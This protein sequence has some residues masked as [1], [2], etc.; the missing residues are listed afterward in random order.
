MKI[1]A[2]NA[3]GYLITSQGRL[4]FRLYDGNEFIDYEIH[5]SDLHVKIIDDDAFFYHPKFRAEYIDHSPT[6]LGKDNV[7]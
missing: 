6:T 5:H 7:T 3:E 4:M 2:K 1:V